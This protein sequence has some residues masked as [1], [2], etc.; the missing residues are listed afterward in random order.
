MQIL[1]KET[2]PSTSGSLNGILSP[3]VKATHSLMAGQTLDMEQWQERRERLEL[4]GRE[5]MPP[6]SYYAEDEEM[7]RELSEL[8]VDDQTQPLFK[9][10]SE[11]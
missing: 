2:K 1:L 7:E 5:Q 6:D 9:P 11:P 3:L 10:C 4:E 8:G